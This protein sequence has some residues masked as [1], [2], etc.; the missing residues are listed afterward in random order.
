MKSSSA[1]TGIVVALATMSGT[2]GVACLED[3]PNSDQCTL[4]CWSIAYEYPPAGGNLDGSCV[5]R[6]SNEGIFV[7]IPVSGIATGRACIDFQADH[8]LVKQVL[9]AAEAGSVASLSAAQKTAWAALA[10]DLVDS[11]H[12]R[13]VTYVTG[14]PSHDDIDPGTAGD[15]SCTDVSASAI[16]DLAVSVPLAA[17][18]SLTEQG[19][20]IAI[21][22]YAG[23]EYGLVAQPECEFLPETTGDVDPTGGPQTDP[24]AD[25]GPVRTDG[26]SA[27]TS[28]GGDGGMFGDIGEGVQCSGTQ[29]SIDMSVWASIINNFDTFYDE[30]VTLV[31]GPSGAPCNATGAKIGG[32]S[33]GEASAELAAA[34][35]LRNGDVITRVEGISLVDL[36]KAAAVVNDLQSTVDPISMTVR[37]KTSA[38]ACTTLNYTIL[39]TN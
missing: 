27:D 8:E 14:G 25:D 10:G 39:L 1:R 34:L 7:P 4:H 2:I 37:R 6:G 5:D 3:N 31:I 13:C 12:S 18:L 35:G 24:T 30:G 20:D 11:A 23:V 36:G 29:C 21:P 26:G 17:S 32:L 22:E 33:N 15:Q 9:Q 38:S 16:C 19:A 28:G